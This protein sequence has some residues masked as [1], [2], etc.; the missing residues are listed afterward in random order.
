MHVP[1]GASALIPRLVC[2]DVAAEIAFCLQALRATETLTRPGPDG[3]PIHA[4]LQ[5]GTAMLMLE[6]EWPSLPSRAPAPDG[7]SPV[8]LYLYVD[9]VD[10][11][12]QRA[13]T[14]GAKLVV[15]LQTQFWGDRIAWIQDP[16]G[17]LWTLATR[18]E[19]TT[20]QERAARWDAIRDKPD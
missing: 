14:L 15:E 3:R 16:Q 17:H 12:V 9:D 2:R 20:E 19:Q 4:M 7:S 8:V 18:V 11:A 6:S 5:F 1:K 10:A 13:L